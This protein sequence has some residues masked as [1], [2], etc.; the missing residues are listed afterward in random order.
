MKVYLD[1]YTSFFQIGALTFGGGMAMLPMLQKEVVEKHRWVTEDEVI[2]Y[3]AIGQVTPGIIAVNTATFV[4]YK[5]KGFLGGIVATAGMVSPSLI[6]ITLIATFIKQFMDLEM[7][8]HAFV[9]I[10]VAVSALIVLSVIRLGKK[11]IKNVI[12]IAIALIAFVVVTFADVSS[13]YI[14]VAAIVF[15]LLW[16]RGKNV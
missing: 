12:G 6:I 9:G 5:V 2:D 11:S 10:R 13:V 15:G 16:K 1:L 8:Q 7:V 14:V 4:G 3:Y